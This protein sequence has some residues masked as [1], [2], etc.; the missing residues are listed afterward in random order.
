M[1]EVADVI[2]LGEIEVE[3]IDPV[4]NELV[5]CMGPHPRARQ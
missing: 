4:G 2:D 1:E 3:R 5:I